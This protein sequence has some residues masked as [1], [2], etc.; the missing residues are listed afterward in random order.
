MFLNE[1][2]NIFIDIPGISEDANLEKFC[3]WVKSTNTSR[4]TER[5]SGKC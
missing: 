2:R 5:R 3:F 1:F 4:G